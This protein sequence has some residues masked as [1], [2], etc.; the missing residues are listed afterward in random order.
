MP[1]INSP[2]PS[3]AA[4]AAGTAAAWQRALGPFARIEMAVEEVVED[5]SAGIQT[6]GRAEQPGQGRPIAQ[7]GH[8]IAGEHV[9]HCRHHVRRAQEFQV[10]A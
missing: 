2:D 9:R 3:A 10:P 7:P 1:P 8:R 6:G 4:P 5:D